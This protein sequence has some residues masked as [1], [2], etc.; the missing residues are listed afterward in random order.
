MVALFRT[1]LRSSFFPQKSPPVT[2]PIPEVESG[3]GDR[4]SKGDHFRSLAEK[5][6]KTVVSGMKRVLRIWRKVIL[7]AGF[8]TAAVAIFL[9]VFAWAPKSGLLAIPL[10]AAWALAIGGAT[11]A[12]NSGKPDIGFVLSQ[13]PFVIGGGWLFYGVNQCGHC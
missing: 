1:A 10:V 13:A 5:E 7:L 6:S 2:D 3:G 11:S 8:P 4:D 9:L 12:A